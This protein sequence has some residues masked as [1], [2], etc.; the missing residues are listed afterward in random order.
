MYLL[1]QVSSTIAPAE[2][3]CGSLGAFGGGSI[4]P[5]HNLNLH[6]HPEY[7]GDTARYVPHR[8]KRAISGQNTTSVV[9]SGCHDS[10]RWDGLPVRE[11]DVVVVR[12]R[13]QRGFVVNFESERVRSK[14]DRELLARL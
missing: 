12:T 3:G 5:D 6:W 14:R 7:Q 8:M 10:I 9:C 4:V 11:H 1:L 2:L 13:Q